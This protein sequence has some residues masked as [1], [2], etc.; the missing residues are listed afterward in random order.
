MH[1]SWPQKE[2]WHFAHCRITAHTLE[3][4]QLELVE[5]VKAVRPPLEKGTA[6]PLLTPFH[7]I[8]QALDDLISSSI[9]LF[10][11]VET[12]RRFLWTAIAEVSPPIFIVKV[13]NLPAPSSASIAFMRREVRIRICPGSGVKGATLLSWSPSD[14]PKRSSRSICGAHSVRDQARVLA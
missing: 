11:R 10:R 13:T 9:S 6:N 2:V 14:S 8:L 4:L 12:E 3:D 5:V 7:V 1:V